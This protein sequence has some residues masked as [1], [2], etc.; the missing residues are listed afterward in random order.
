MR[1]LLKPVQYSFNSLKEA[2]DMSFPNIEVQEFSNHAARGAVTFYRIYR[3]FPFG[4]N[5]ELGYLDFFFLGCS[6]CTLFSI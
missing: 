4:S 6:F 5:R 3:L 1:L 2:N